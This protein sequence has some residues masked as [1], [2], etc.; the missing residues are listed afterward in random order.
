[1]A[2]GVPVVARSAGNLRT[3]ADRFPSIH[4]AD[5]VAD[6]VRTVG[7][8]SGRTVPFEERHAVREAFS[9]TAQR[10]AVNSALDAGAVRP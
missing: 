6:V 10:A 3:L 8:V 7:S 9:V 5:E 4:L 2:H 1:V